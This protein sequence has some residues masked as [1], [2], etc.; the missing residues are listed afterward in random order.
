MLSI[1][2]IR[3]DPEYV[4]NALR[5]RGEENSLEVILDLD[6]R[7]RQGISEGDELRSQRNL[8]SRRIGELRGSGQNVPT[9]LVEDMRKVGER[10]SEI[11]QQVKTVELSI[12]EI[13]MALPNL[14]REDVPHGLDEESNV[15]VRYWGEV[16]E[17]P[18]DVIPHWD[19][20]E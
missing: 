3:K 13:L 12:H 17:S 20:G 8:V 16:V 14:P 5:L 9:D 4:K 10:I 19:L 2:L 6:V 18:F 15:V 7:R 1:D 11:E